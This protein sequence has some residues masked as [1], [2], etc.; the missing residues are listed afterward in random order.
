MGSPFIK[1]TIYSLSSDSKAYEGNRP[2]MKYLC[3]SVLPRRRNTCL[4]QLFRFP[5]KEILKR[6]AR[7]TMLDNLLTNF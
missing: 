5:F 3:R 4:T 2:S 7:K 6:R 1:V